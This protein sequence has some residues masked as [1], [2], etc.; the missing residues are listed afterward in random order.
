MYTGDIKVLNIHADL[1]PHCPDFKDL[2]EY[3]SARD[4]EGIPV[5]G[6]AVKRKKGN[7]DTHV[8]GKR[9][10]GDQTDTDKTRKIRSKFD[11][12]HFFIDSNNKLLYFLNRNGHEVLCV[13]NVHNSE[14]ESLR[15]H[16]FME[17]HDSPFYGHRGAV[18]T[19]GIMRA[20]FYWPKMY[21]NIQQYISCCPEC[22]NNKIDRTKPKGLLQPLQNPTSPGQSL[23][24]D[25]ATDL[26]RSY[27]RGAWYD[28]A[29]I[30]VDR[31]SHRAYGLL[32]RKNNSAEE[33][34]S[35]FMHEYVLGTMNG[36]PH[37]LIGD[38]DTIFTS[39]HFDHF[40]RRLG[41]SL[42]LS[43]ARSQQ[44]N[45]RLNVKSPHLKRYFVMA[46]TIARIIGQKCSNT[47]SSR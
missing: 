2:Y 42:R 23:N 3:L 12:S 15:Y 25:F 37:E 28:T 45:G 13:P 36:L 6:T 39:H 7:T 30:L 20:R 24:M 8:P 22:Q 5:P 11:P 35:L 17:C 29:W 14:G 44:S 1:Y 41:I 40:S 47:H 43:S 16:I 27:Y 9:Q 21:D 32:C 34:C 33:L 19:Y 38:R 10:K 18:A 4:I 31:C 26:P 46:S